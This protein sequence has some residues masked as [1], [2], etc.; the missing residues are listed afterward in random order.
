MHC[1]IKPDNILIEHGFE[2]D[3]LNYSSHIYLIDFGIS[4][5]YIEADGSHSIKHKMPTFDGNLAFASY[6]HQ[7]MNSKIYRFILE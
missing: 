6:N 1:D 7:A 5:T 4:T 2:S 3:S